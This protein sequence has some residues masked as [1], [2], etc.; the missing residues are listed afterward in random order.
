MFFFRST[1]MLIQSLNM[2][3]NSIS[4]KNFQKQNEKIITLENCC[5]LTFFICIVAL[6]FICGFYQ[7]LFFSAKNASEQGF[8]FLSKLFIVFSVYDTNFKLFILFYKKFIKF[9]NCFVILY[10]FRGLLLL[11]NYLNLLNCFFH[12]NWCCNISA[13]SSFSMLPGKLKT[14]SE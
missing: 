7:F 14:H 9:I 4:E 1:L 13:F 10:Y 12:L 2:Y 11:K 5:Q 6:L 8:T 3:S